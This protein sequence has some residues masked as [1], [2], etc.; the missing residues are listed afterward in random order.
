MIRQAAVKLLSWIGW[1]AAAHLAYLLAQIAKVVA[2]GTAA[3]LTGVSLLWRVSPWQVQIFPT[4]RGD[5]SSDLWF[6][7]QWPLS[8]SIDLALLTCAFLLA[9]RVSRSED[10]ARLG[11]LR[12]IVLLAGLWVSASRL[13]EIGRFQLAGTGRGLRQFFDVLSGV[14]QPVVPA[15]VL[16]MLG[17][18]VAV[19]GMGILNG[20]FA[21]LPEGSPSSFGRRLGG[22]FPLFLAVAGQTVVAARVPQRLGQATALDWVWAGPLFVAAVLV[23][24]SVWRRRAV[25]A[26][27]PGPKQAAVAMGLALVLTAGL[28][29][30]ERILL[31]RSEAE[32]ASVRTAH[33]EI[34]YDSQHWSEA[35]AAA[36]AA[37]RESRFARFNERLPW[38]DD[39]VPLRIV[40]YPDFRALW[41]SGRRFSFGQRALELEGTTARAVADGSELLLSPVD[42]ARLYLAGAWGESRSPLVATW[43]G[44][45]LIG[46]W[47]GHPLAEWAGRLRLEGEGLSLAELVDEGQR[48][49]LPPSQG[50]LI[51]GTWIESIAE[52][53]SVEALRELY[54]STP[55][56][57]SLSGLSALL[58]SSPR[59]VEERWQEWVASA[60]MRS[61]PRPAPRVHD[62]RFQR[63]MSL[64]PTELPAS[65]VERELVRLDQLG[66]DSVALITHEHYR[67]GTGIQYHAN[68]AANDERLIRAIRSAHRLGMRVLLK[69]QVYGGEAGFAGNICIEEPAARALWMESYRKLI[70]H[71]ARMAQ[72]E[73]VALFSVG[74]ELGCLTKHEADWRKFIASVRRIYSGPLTYAANWGEE[75]ETLRFWDALDFIGLNNYYP[76]T[77]WPGQGSDQML[78]RAKAVA[79]KVAQIHQRWQRPVLFTEAGFPSV[80]GG[81]FRPWDPP[82]REPDVSEQAAG[83]A[84]IIQAGGDQ[85]WL[86]GIF[87]WA[88][89]DGELSPAGKPAE[90][91]LS[92]WYRR[93]A[94]VGN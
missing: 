4:S 3:G 62:N 59:D 67:G 85:P 10:S 70:L 27:L 58:G 94:E 17:L 5:A 54:K 60:A 74:N 13:W 72:D 6:R 45:W 80:R 29:G 69:P 57:L 44:R 83:Y 78:I 9:R 39:G 21:R 63:G 93:L 61:R 68:T 18:V 2:A 71:Y 82:S 30:A 38:P 25:A 77:E 23:V 8:F 64:K 19:L 56:R 48:D 7:W 36:F 84:A 22:A 41:R 51:G 15:L 52:D 26:F 49:G 33:Y 42:D 11:N 88:W 31:W 35:Q 90:Q 87:W 1:L 81:T 73:G 43:V 16:L 89:H 40:V 47:Q 37:E 24:W 66:T 14:G 28:A 92:T 86:R 46:E 50:E 79:M 12:L 55:E 76:L 91:I 75:F 53:S 65:V 32:L 20:L 34:L